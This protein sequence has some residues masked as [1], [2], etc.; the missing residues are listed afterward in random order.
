LKKKLQNGAIL[1]SGDRLIHLCGSSISLLKQ[2][3]NSR[4]RLFIS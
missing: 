2:V 3:F 4:S 1:I